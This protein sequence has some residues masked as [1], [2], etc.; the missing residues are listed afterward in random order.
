MNNELKNLPPINT[1]FALMLSLFLQMQSISLLGISI[2]L[3]LSALKMNISHI[4]LVMALYSIGLIL[5]SFQGKKVI[6]NVGHIRAFSGFAAIATIVAITHNL[7]SNAYLFAILRVLSGLSSAIMLVVVESWFNT[8]CKN[9]HRSRLLAIHQ[10]VLYLAMGS[11]QLLINLT[12]GQLNSAFLV[13]ALLSCM[14]LIPITLIR[15]D[16]PKIVNTQPIPFIELFQAAPTGIIGAICA[17]NAIG[18]I[19]N[20]SPLFAQQTQASTWDISVFMSAIIFSGILLQRPIGL[21]ADKYPREYILY[22]LLV[23]TVISTQL[24]IHFSHFISLTLMGVL[25]GAPIACLYPISIA[26]VYTKFNE[27]KSVA[28]SSGLLLAYALGGFT[29]PVFASFAMNIFGVSA[30]FHYLS[31]YCVLAIFICIVFLRA[32]SINK[33]L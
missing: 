14:A 2:P 23:F 25:L 24:A 32:Q 13:A 8:L 6:S 4:G 30:L 31:F 10:I 26:T 7:A 12:P 5:G 29:G 15:I 22:A 9:H 16:N 27:E 17:G 28:A 33:L 11:G 20:L 1:I 21:L 18:T 3:S 19:F